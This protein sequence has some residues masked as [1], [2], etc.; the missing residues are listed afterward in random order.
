MMRHG[1]AIVIAEDNVD[2]D[3]LYPGKYLNVL[4]PQKARE[5]LFEGLDPSLRD[6]LKQG[7][8]V[9]FVGN[10]FGTGSSREQPATA[11]LASGVGAIVGNSFARIFARNAVNCGM[12]ALVN[13]AAVLAVTPG[14]DVAVDIA[15]GT[16]R[17]GGTEYPSVP[18]A[19]LPH[20]IVVAGGLVPWIRS[21]AGARALTQQQE[22]PHAR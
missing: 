20:A 18:L 15:S 12:P 5:H 9:L 19:P 14:C 13:P 1:K 7:P 21:G 17:I 6:L 2:T 16:V 8:T 10:N 22:V 4:D 3:V 11:M